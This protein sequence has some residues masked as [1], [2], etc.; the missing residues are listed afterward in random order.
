M[1]CG[2]LDVFERWDDR[3]RKEEGKGALGWGSG[4]EWLER[5]NFGT[6]P[7]AKK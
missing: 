2:E 7:K 1:R 3:K 4:G 5:G 6:V